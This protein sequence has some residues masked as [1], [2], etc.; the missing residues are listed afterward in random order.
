MLSGA[1]VVTLAPGLT[2]NEV[3]ELM[4]TELDPTDIGTLTVNAPPAL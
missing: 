1:A 3:L 2:V 4:S